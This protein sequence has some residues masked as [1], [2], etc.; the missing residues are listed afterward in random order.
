MIEFFCSF[1]I[2]RPSPCI[3][4]SSSSIDRRVI[5][6]GFWLYYAVRDELNTM[7]ALNSLNYEY[8]PISDVIVCVW[9]TEER[10]KNRLLSIKFS[11][12]SSGKAS[13]VEQTFSKSICMDEV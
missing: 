2:S 5:R 6:V 3:V 13:A 4:P 8:I 9:F 12:I 10:K 1:V 7:T 11:R